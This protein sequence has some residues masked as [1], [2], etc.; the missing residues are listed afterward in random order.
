MSQKIPKLE[1]QGSPWASGETG[2]TSTGERMSCFYGRAGAFR[3]FGGGG[4]GSG[5]IVARTQRRRQHWVGLMC[6]WT[7]KG[8]SCF[9]H[10]SLSIPGTSANSQ[11]PSVHKAAANPPPSCPRGVKCASNPFPT[12]S[13]TQQTYSRS[14]VRHYRKEG[15]AN[16]TDLLLQIVTF[17]NVFSLF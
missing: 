4:V 10:Q 17:Q 13:I 15:M 3:G 2:G 9:D 5:C 11:V 12:H 6:D 8:L 16:P 14:S 1:L 7:E